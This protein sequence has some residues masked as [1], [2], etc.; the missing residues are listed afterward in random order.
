[1]WSLERDKDVKSQLNKENCSLENVNRELNAKCDEFNRLLEQTRSE[2]AMKESQYNTF[3]DV[4]SSLEKE[5]TRVFVGN[6]KRR[7]LIANY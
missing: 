5:H 3:V 1:M 6:L 7:T 2:L 4:H